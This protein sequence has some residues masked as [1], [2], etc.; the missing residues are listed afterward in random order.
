MSIKNEVVFRCDGTVSIGTEVPE[1][2]ARLA[3]LQRILPTLKGSASGCWEWQDYC[4]PEWGYGQIGYRG[5]PWMLH[6]LMWTL[7]RGEIPAGYVICHRCDNP[8]CCN[9]DHL[10]VG[11]DADNVLDRV[12]K[13]RDHHANL[14]ECPRGHPYSGDNLWVDSRGFR[15]CRACQR[16]RNKSPEYIAQRREY[17]RKRRLERRSLR[18]GEQ[19]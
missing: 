8:P 9:P 19:R 15:Q 10:F 18:T 5:K 7:L 4:H 3:I 14:T 1:P 17:Q 11:S 13:R 6:R 12:A 2:L 16:A